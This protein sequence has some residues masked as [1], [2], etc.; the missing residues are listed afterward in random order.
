M[1]TLLGE[2]VNLPTP[3]YDRF[4]RE[5]GISPVVNWMRGMAGGWEGDDL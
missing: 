5:G 1:E 3:T 2:S 4:A